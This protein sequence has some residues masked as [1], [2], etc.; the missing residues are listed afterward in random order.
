MQLP[1]GNTTNIIKDHQLV[2]F[3]NVISFTVLR[4]I[5]EYTPTLKKMVHLD[6]KYLNRNAVN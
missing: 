5:K 1:F 3:V 4:Q 2:S 6:I